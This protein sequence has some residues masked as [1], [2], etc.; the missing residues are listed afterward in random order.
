M[1]ARSNVVVQFLRIT[2]NFC[3]HKFYKNNWFNSILL[4]I[5][6]Y[7][8]GIPLL[9]NVRSYR[10]SQLL[11]TLASNVS[12]SLRKKLKMNDIDLDVRCNYWWG[13][14]VCCFLVWK[15]TVT[16]LSNFDGSESVSQIKQ[17][18]KRIKNNQN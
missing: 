13:N 2:P 12:C 11:Q 14:T 6:M 8:H 3:I 1:G 17:F 16:V 4:Q 5:F 10:L 15:K 7:G 9:E 18:P